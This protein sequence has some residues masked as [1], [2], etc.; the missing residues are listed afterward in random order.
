MEI[1]C[2]AYLLFLSAG[3]EANTQLNWASEYLPYILD[4][5]MRLYVPRRG[6]PTLKS[7]LLTIHHMQPFRASVLIQE[8]IRYHC[9]VYGILKFAKLKR[10]TFKRHIWDYEKGNYQ[11]LREQASLV[12]WPALYDDNIDTYSVN[13]TSKIIDLAKDNIPNRNITIHPSDPPWITSA[14]KRYIRKRK[15]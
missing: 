4:C 13:I 2:Q 7:V 12:D 8:D 1:K 10:K 9:P 14:L 5:C 6:L 15:R 11:S 3:K